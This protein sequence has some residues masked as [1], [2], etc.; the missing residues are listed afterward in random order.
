MPNEPPYKHQTQPE[1][2]GHFTCN[3]ANKKAENLAINQSET[4][5]SF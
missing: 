3:S 1:A 4:A 5:R 2:V